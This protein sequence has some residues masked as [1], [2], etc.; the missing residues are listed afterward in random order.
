MLYLP[1]G[2]S[3]PIR[4]QGTFVSDKEVE[5]IVVFVKSHC[6]AVYDPNIME[7][8]EQQNK[9]PQA[10]QE[11]QSDAD[12]LLVDAIELAVQMGNASASMIQRKFKVG[13]ARAGRIID[14][15]EERGIVSGYDGSKPRQTLISQEQWEEMKEAGVDSVKFEDVDEDEYEEV[16]ED[17][18]DEVEEDDDTLA[19]DEEVDEDEEVEEEDEESEDDEEEEEDEEVEDDEEE[20]EDDDDEDKR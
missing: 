11:Q 20:S 9:P 6:E 19:E 2:E 16:E 4:V 17:V 13:Y 1:I 3:K 7:T 10:V 14:Q 8:F 18:E 5:S 12:E 15:M